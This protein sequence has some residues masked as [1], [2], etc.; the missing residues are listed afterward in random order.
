MESGRGIHI[1]ITKD[2][3]LMEDFAY[4]L[5]TRSF[6]REPQLWK[7][8]QWNSTRWKMLRIGEPT[9]RI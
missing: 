9:Y 3:L 5:Q 4:G 7:E 8:K 1:A 6:V 2:V